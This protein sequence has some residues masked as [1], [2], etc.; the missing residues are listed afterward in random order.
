MA[1]RRKIEATGENALLPG[2]PVTPAARRPGAGAI[3]PRQKKMTFYLPADLDPQLH[4]VY[5]SFLQQYR[6]VSKSA[7]V[8]I[9]IGLALE[10][11]RKNPEKSPL[12]KR[13]SQLAQQAGDSG[14]P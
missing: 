12:A 7:I 4:E 3:R 14:I 11:H 6:G 10:E 5:A 8:G 1:K 2:A 13:V 9:A